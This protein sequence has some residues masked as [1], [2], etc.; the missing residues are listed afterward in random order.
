MQKYWLKILGVS[1]TKVRGNGEKAI[2]DVRCVFSGVQGGRARAGVAVL[3]SER[4]GRCLKKWNGVNERIL[5]LRLKVEGT[6]CGSQH[7]CTNR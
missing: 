6:V 3:L 4:L 7:V 2:G 1:V 5:R